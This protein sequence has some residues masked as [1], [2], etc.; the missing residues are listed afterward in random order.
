MRR[1]PSNS[2]AT[3]GPARRRSSTTGSVSTTTAMSGGG[4]AE[5]VDHLVER[6]A[7]TVVTG[8]PTDHQREVAQIVAEAGHLLEPVDVD[9]R[10]DGRPWRSTTTR[11]RGRRRPPAGP[12]PAGWPR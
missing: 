7:A 3:T 5:R 2:A 1:R 8:R 10:G 11:G 4:P 6:R 9:H 12:R